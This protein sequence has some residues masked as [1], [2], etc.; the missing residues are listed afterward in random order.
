[1]VSIGRAAGGLLLAMWLAAGSAFAGSLILLV[2]WT[3]LICDIP[4]EEAAAW[5]GLGA[6]LA[7]AVVFACT[8]F[9]LLAIWLVV[10]SSSIRVRDRA[11]IAAAF[12]LLI[13][14]GIGA[15][16]W[17]DYE[18]SPCYEQAGKVCAQPTAPL[19]GPATSTLRPR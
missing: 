11:L 8:G 7:A 5:C 2:L 16:S 1:V 12:W 9:V 17:Y 19:P 10:L 18:R 13:Y 6:F 14:G 15:W 4:S 3:N